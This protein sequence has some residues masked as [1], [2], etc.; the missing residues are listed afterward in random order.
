MDGREEAE[1]AGKG[2][3]RKLQKSI[4]RGQ[5]RKLESRQA[6]LV[7]GTPGRS[8]PHAPRLQPTP[9]PLVGRG[10]WGHSVAGRQG[11]QVR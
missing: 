4:C 1:E 5:A 11:F 6:S 10:N 7:H 2:R 3:E 9:T 8:S